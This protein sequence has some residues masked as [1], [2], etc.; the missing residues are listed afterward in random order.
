MI[1]FPDTT[2]MDVGPGLV[3]PLIG[4]TI[5]GEEGPELPLPMG[6]VEPMPMGPMLRVL[7]FWIRDLPRYLSGLGFPKRTG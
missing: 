6:I 1:P 3:L 5:F 2:T 4:H 7:E